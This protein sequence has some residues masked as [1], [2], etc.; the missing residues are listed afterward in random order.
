MKSISTQIKTNK[1]VSKEFEAGGGGKADDLDVARGNFT[2][3]IAIGES[4]SKGRI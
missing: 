2:G 4:D 1:I 3:G